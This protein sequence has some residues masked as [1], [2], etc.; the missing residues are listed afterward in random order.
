MMQSDQI[1][2]I[3]LHRMVDDG[4]PNTPSGDTQVHDLTDFMVVLGNNDLMD[5]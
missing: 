5:M 1:E 2:R 3:E 4:C